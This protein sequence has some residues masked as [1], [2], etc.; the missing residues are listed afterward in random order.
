MTE[1]FG[2]NSSSQQNQ[3]NALYP[4]FNSADIEG[5]KPILDDAAIQNTLDEPVAETIVNPSNSYI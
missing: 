5:Q 4:G 1:L 2:L 3:G